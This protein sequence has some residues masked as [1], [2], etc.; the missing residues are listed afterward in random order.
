MKHGD[1]LSGA[2]RSHRDIASQRCPLSPMGPTDSALPL[3][4]A[5]V[6]SCPAQGLFQGATNQ[7]SQGTGLI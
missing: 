1:M 4:Q 5:A 7:Y 6:A 2:R 3:G